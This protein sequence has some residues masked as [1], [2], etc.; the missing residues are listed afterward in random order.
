MIRILLVEDDTDLNLT[1]RTFLTRRGY[2][3]SSCLD[4]N[5]AWDEIAEHH[6]DLVVSDIMMENV[7]GFEFAG[8][9]REDNKTLPI[10]FISALDDITSKSRGFAEGI[11]DYIVKPVNFEELDLRIK[12]LLRR[13]GIKENKRIELSDFTMDEDERSVYLR[14]EEV[15]LTT[16]EFNI[17]YKLLSYPKKTFTRDALMSEFW[18]LESEAASR[19]VDVYITRIREKVQDA[20]SFEIRTVH[21]LGYKAVL[22]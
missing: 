22:L 17:L 21:G 11:D 16:R 15:R 18:P 6:I 5:E 2:E 9:L 14:G 12:A 1:M 19:T 20:M 13:A 8:M 7:N 3:V 10:I 4:V